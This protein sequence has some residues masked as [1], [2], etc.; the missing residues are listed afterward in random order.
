MELKIC[1]IDYSV[2]RHCMGENIPTVSPG[3]KYS[4]NLYCTSLGMTLKFFTKL[5]KWPSKFTFPLLYVFSVVETEYV[6]LNSSA[7]F[8]NPNREALRLN[9]LNDF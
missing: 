1:R 9:P 2:R 8:Y 3:P 4:L 5:I 7:D 6:G